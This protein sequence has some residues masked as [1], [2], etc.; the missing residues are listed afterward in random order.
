MFSSC[1]L[2]TDSETGDAFFDITD[3]T[4]VIHFYGVSDLSEILG[5]IHLYYYIFIMLSFFQ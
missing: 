4:D 5:K 1:V 3:I 2:S